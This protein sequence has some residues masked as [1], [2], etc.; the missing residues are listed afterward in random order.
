[1]SPM[2]KPAKPANLLSIAE[3]LF[4]QHKTKTT[5]QITKTSQFS[6][7][8][9]KHNMGRGNNA[10]SDLWQLSD[11]KDSTS[12]DLSALLHSDALASKG[13]EIRQQPSYIECLGLYR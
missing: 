10:W 8:L 11:G 1:M 13:N 9:T 4:A 7:S 6:S 3:L 12:S 5:S 2:H